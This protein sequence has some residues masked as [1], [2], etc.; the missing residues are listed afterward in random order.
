[1]NWKSTSGKNQHAKHAK[2]QKDLIRRLTT[3]S[4]NRE[5]TINYIKGTGEIGKVKKESVAS[6]QGYKQP[7]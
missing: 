2:I 6:F 1:L 7:Y 4:P 3:G 5:H